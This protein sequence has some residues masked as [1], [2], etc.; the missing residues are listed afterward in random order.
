METICMIRYSERTKKSSVAITTQIITKYIIA[1]LVQTTRN[2][3]S[4]LPTQSISGLLRFR[5]NYYSII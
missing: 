3:V 1:I 4:F 2:Q 5:P